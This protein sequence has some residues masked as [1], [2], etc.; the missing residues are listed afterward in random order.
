MKQ[1]DWKIIYTKYDGI[2]KKA[3]ELL[4]KEVS[5]FLI[6]EPHVYSI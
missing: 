6:R 2:S 3:I 1:T 4:S 5:E